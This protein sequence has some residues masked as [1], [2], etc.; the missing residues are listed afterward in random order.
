MIVVCQFA[1]SD[2]G[3]AQ[4]F[5]PKFLATTI[6]ILL[7]LPAYSL[8]IS[9]D[10]HLE[11]LRQLRNDLLRRRMWKAAENAVYVL[12]VMLLVFC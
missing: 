1:A 5:L 6:T 7:Q 9:D 12:P 10:G 2:T 11:V 3:S 8:G 4:K